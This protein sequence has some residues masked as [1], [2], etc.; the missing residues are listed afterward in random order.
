MGLG[1]HICAFAALSDTTNI[2]SEIGMSPLFRP[3]SR[4]SNTSSNRYM[5]RSSY[6]APLLPVRTART[7]TDKQLQRRLFACLVT[8]LDANRLHIQTLGCGCM[9]AVPQRHIHRYSW[10]SLRT[11]HGPWLGF[12]DITYRRS[13]AAGLQISSHTSHP[14]NLASG[15]SIVARHM[16]LYLIFQPFSQSRLRPVCP[17]YLWYKK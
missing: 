8:D 2:G 5:P 14:S 4:L 9:S 3:S 16:S 11:P 17:A 12:C 1:M 15:R 7:I 6:A 10:G 13:I